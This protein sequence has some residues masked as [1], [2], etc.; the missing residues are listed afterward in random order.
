MTKRDLSSLAQARAETAGIVSLDQLREF[1]FTPSAIR[2]Q[3]DAGR[4]QQVHP[5]VYAVHTGELSWQARAWAA[6]R[7]AGADSVLSHGSGA[8]VG[9]WHREPPQTIDVTVPYNR[10]VLPQPLLCTHRSRAY[11]H[12]VEQGSWPPRTTAARTVVD[13]LRMCSSQEEALALLLESMRRR[14]ATPATLWPE[15]TADKR[16]RFRSLV[17][18]AIDDVARGVHSVLEKRYS[19]LENLHGLPTGRRQ[20]EI[21]VGSSREFQDVYYDGYSLIVELDGRIGH[22]S[23]NGC[24][25]CDATT[26][27][28]WPAGRPCVLATSI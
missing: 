16:L 19:E 8:H 5:R 13:L 24:A 27:T 14:W 12:V 6:L 4:W 22:E 1:G 9:G 11:L 10:V 21:R 23:V 17:S 20:H 15:V 26:A 28:R 7:Y 25:T 3:L 2:A 18:A